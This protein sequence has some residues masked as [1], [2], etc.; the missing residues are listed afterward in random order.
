MSNALALWLK[1]H[2]K[3]AIAH[4]P[5]LLSDFLLSAAGEITTVLPG[6]LKMHL[7]RFKQDRSDVLLSRKAGI[8]YDAIEE[9]V[10][11]ELPHP[12]RFCEQD[13]PD[14]ENN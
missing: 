4:V 12:H 13:P 3:L 6:D 2:G 9:I 14:A 11:A 10:A 1:E 8:Y 7:Q 5:Q